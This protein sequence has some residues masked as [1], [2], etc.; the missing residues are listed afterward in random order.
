MRKHRVLVDRSVRRLHRLVPGLVLLVGIALVG[1]GE[2]SSAM[3]QATPVDTSVA[4]SALFVGDSHLRGAVGTLQRRLVDRPGGLATTF[5]SFGGL[6]VDDSTYLA[7]RVSGAIEASGGFDVVVIGLGTNDVI[8]G[9]VTG[10]AAFHI[11][12]IIGAAGETPVL[13]LTLAETMV[14][15][16]AAVGF[17]AELRSA[18]DRHP[19][20][21]LIDFG[22]E[23]DQHPE[24]FASD[25]VHLSPVGRAAYSDAIAGAVDSVVG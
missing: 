8:D 5:N 20:L 19:T 24:Y 3:M 14:A 21:A 17:N 16:A 9:Q 11:D 6:G 22:P 23:W 4:A 10:D 25:A 18:L 2:P 1:G 7:A 15:R 13:W 12:R